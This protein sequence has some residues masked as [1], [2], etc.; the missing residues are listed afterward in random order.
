MRAFFIDYVH[1]V[2]AIA[3]YNHHFVDKFSHVVVGLLVWL[4]VAAATRRALDAWLPLLAI[5]GLEG[6]QELIEW[7]FR[8]GW[9]LNDAS[10]DFLATMLFPCLIGLTMRLVP[11]TRGCPLRPSEFDSNEP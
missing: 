5:A 9:T 3:E 4:V 1:I 8:T 10:T 7:V 6:V 2:D 11:S